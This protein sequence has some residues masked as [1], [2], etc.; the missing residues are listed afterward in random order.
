MTQLATR[1]VDQ[2]LMDDLMCKG[3]VVDRSLHELDVINKWLGGNQVTIDGLSRLFSTVKKGRPIVIADIGC[4]SGDMVMRILRWGLKEGRKP[5]VVGIDANPNIVS[6]A[7]AKCRD[8][9]DVSFKVMNV[10][11]DEFARQRFD[12][13]VATLFMHHFTNEQ[14]TKLF[15]KLRDQTRIGFVVNDIHRHPV[16]FHSIRLLTSIFSRSEMVKH[17]GPLSVQR[18]FKKSDLK[19][20]L[21]NA[22]IEDYSLKWKWAFRWQ[23]IVRS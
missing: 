10:L 2:E 12:V 17:D 21:S 9:P 6:Y 13:V 19:N 1:S 11:D 23:L 20:I 3:E 18:A 4:G 5:E 15:R 22:G 16:A 14:L 7:R 8:Y